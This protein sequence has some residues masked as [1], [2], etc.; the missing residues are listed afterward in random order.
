MLKSISLLLTILLAFN[1]ITCKHIEYKEEGTTGVLK[2]SYPMITSLNSKGLDEINDILN[3]INTN[4]IKALI[5]DTLFDLSKLS[6]VD[7]ETQKLMDEYIQYG[8]ETNQDIQVIPFPSINPVSGFL[9]LLNGEVVKSVITG[10]SEFDRTPGM[11]EMVKMTKTEAE[12]FSQKGNNVLRKIETF[13]I[14]V[15]FIGSSSYIGSGLQ[16]A[17]SCDIRIGSDKMTF[18]LPEVS[19]GIMPGFGGTQRL[20]RIIGSGM[21]NQLIFT[22]GY[23]EAKEA[24][25]YGLVSAIYPTDTLLHEA[26][27]IAESLGKNSLNAIKNSKKAINDGLNENIDKALIIE[28]KLFGDCFET[29]DQKMRMKNFI[30]KNKKI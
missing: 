21:A 30:N 29:Q 10:E 19:Y 6:S 28:E 16:I 9:V 18:G 2:I 27:K 23:L 8:K 12:K 25:E 22:G 15:I 5:I 24:L 7:E 17:L 26:K 3:K 14:P 4:I 13:P 1:I 11:E 20:A